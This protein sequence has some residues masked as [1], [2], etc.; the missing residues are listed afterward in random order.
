MKQLILIS[1]LNSFF[2][3][4]HNQDTND[5]NFLERSGI[6]L[7]LGAGR[8]DIYNK[9]SL[10]KPQ[11]NEN[12]ISLKKKSAQALGKF[13]YDLNN[14]ILAETGVR[15]FQFNHQTQSVISSISDTTTI[16]FS[17]NRTFNSLDFPLGISFKITPY[18][19]AVISVLGGASFTKFWS[20]ELES[21]L[22]NN[23]NRSIASS[24]YL[25]LRIS[26]HLTT[27]WHIVFEAR[28]HEYFSDLNQSAHFTSRLSAP[29]SSIGI[30]YRFQ[31]C[32]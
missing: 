7:S 4:A 30:G 28:T 14:F 8:S 11:V 31:S 29:M 12:R 10:P 27:N 23:L 22:F 20:K 1:I 9:N 21:T 5:L 32:D 17:P 24:W 3:N 13:S 15:F 18:Q 2:L 26:T 6:Q 25:G 19:K 16:L